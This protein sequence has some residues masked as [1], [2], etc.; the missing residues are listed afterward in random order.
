MKA[1]RIFFVMSILTISL[2]SHAQVRNERDEKMVSKIDL[3]VD[4]TDIPC[5]TITFGYDNAKRLNYI[6]YKTFR[7]EYSEW[8]RVG[9]T[10][11]RKEHSLN[12]IYKPDQYSYV[13]DE[14]G[15]IIEKEQ[16][17]IGLD[18]SVLAHKYFFYY[19]N[20]DRLCRLHE[21]CYYNDYGKKP[22]ELSDRDDIYF[23]YQGG[24]CYESVVHGYKWKLSDGRELE[25]NP[26]PIRWMN[27]TYYD[28][29]YNDTNIDFYC[30]HNERR[31]R[32]FE[33]ATEWIYNYSV[34]MVE[35]VGAE[36]FK[37]FFDDEDK[38]NIVEMDVYFGTDLRKR[39]KIYYVE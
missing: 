39:C 29:L 30:L 18:R 33:M 7:G 34:N 19:N 17:C 20:I 22:V 12:D 8:K 15:R 2:S 28:D 10:L 27:R 37:Y 9:N 5:L 11:T 38:G 3:F 35:Q 36:R 24:N 23:D 31:E 16:K 21:R 32:H 6:L 26:Y 4:E 14:S 25:E 1:I 13:M